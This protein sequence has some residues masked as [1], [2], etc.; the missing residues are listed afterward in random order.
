MN[1]SNDSVF[2]SPVKVYYNFSPERVTYS[3]F[4]LAILVHL[5][6]METTKIDY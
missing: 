6:F 3:A 1:F 2:E 5:F 4:F